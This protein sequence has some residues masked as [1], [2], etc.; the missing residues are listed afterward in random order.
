ME[1]LHQIQMLI[2]RELLFK[3][4]ARFSELNIKGL[5]ND[6]FSYHINT[7]IDLDLVKKIEGKY[8]LTGK[9][10]EYASRIDTDQVQIEKQPKIGVLVVPY[11]YV[12]GKK[13]LLIQ[14]RTKEPYFGYRGFL[15]GKVRY[16]EKIKETAKRE[17]KEETGLDCNNFVIKN[18][19]HDQ[20]VMLEDGKLM[21]DKLFF[22]TLAKSPKGKLVNTENGKNFWVTE[23]EFIKLDKKY[24]NE[25]EIYE[26]SKMR[27]HLAL[28]E[29]T[30]TIQ[31]F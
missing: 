17:L 28:F 16:G 26:N 24:Y 10:K 1:E 2:L 4:Q 5:S 13:Y 30:Y 21:E 7:L 15:T 3:P 22:I 25:V 9:G 31:E 29:N 11:K 14:E 8:S 6:H 19:F 18:M 12:K 27:G 23:D 20:V